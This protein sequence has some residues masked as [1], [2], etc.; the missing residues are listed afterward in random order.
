M[1]KGDVVSRSEP[2]SG[3]EFIDNAIIN[4]GNSMMVADS[5]R[6]NATSKTNYRSEGVNALNVIQGETKVSLSGA[7]QL[8]IGLGGIHALASDLTTV[9]ADVN[10]A[11]GISAAFNYVDRSV[12]ALISDSDIRSIDGDLELSAHNLRQVN[13]T[14]LIAPV[15]DPDSSANPDPRQQAGLFAV[16]VILGKTE[17]SIKQSVIETLS[18]S[19]QASNT[20]QVSST[21]EGGIE[22]SIDPSSPE[23]QPHVRVRATGVGV[24]VN[25]IGYDIK[26]ALLASIDSLLGNPGDLGAVVSADQF[27]TIADSELVIGGQLS[28]RA[29][30]SPALLA[31]ISNL[32][33]ADAT[34]Q[35]RGRAMSAAGLIAANRVNSHTE[36]L[37]IVNPVLD[38]STVPVILGASGVIEATDATS[39]L[40]DI[41]LAST[42]QLGGSTST[43]GDESPPPSYTT[44]AGQVNGVTSVAGLVAFNELTGGA[45]AAVSGVK[46]LVESGNFDVLASERSSVVSKVESEVLVNS[47]ITGG[48][49][50]YSP[51]TLGGSKSLGASG[52]VAAN[53]VVAKAE[54]DVTQS[55]IQLN[56]LSGG[57]LTIDALNESQILASAKNGVVADLVDAVTGSSSGISPA[58]TNAFGVT[59]AVNSVGYSVLDLLLNTLD[60]LLG[61]RVLEAAGLPGVGTEVGSGATALLKDSVVAVTGSVFVLAESTLEIEASVSNTT[62]AS[63]SGKR[64]SQALSLGA[65]I[66]MNRVSAE[67]ESQ[68]DHANSPAGVQIAAATGIEVMAANRAGISSTIHL[69]T[70]SVLA[71]NGSTNSGSYYAYGSSSSSPIDALGVAGAISFNEIKGGAIAE[72]IDLDIEAESGAIH[73]SALDERVISAK[74]VSELSASST[75]LR[76]KGFGGGKAIGVS[77][78]VAANAVLGATSAHVIRSSVRTRGVL[79]GGDLTVEA[80]SR[81]EVRAE[82]INS[83]DS[84]LVKPGRPGSGPQPPVA[85]AASDAVG[86]VLA[87]N[88]VGWESPNLLFNTIDAILG[89]PLLASAFGEE[90]GAG[91]MAEIRDSRVDVA[92]AVDVISMLDSVIHSSVNNTTSASATGQ[93]GT[94]A[95]SLG[96][97]LALNKISSESVARIEFSNAFIHPLD[98]S[99]ER[100]PNVIGNGVQVRSVDQAAIR[101]EI[102]LGTSSIL[103]LNQKTSTVTYGASTVAGSSLGIAGAISYNEVRSGSSA[104]I[105]NASVEAL[106]GDIVVEAI[107]A[108]VIEARTTSELAASSED[109]SKKRVGSN[110]S[111]GVSGLVSINLVLNASSARL[112]DA[113]VVTFDTAPNSG[114]VRI[115][116]RNE[117]LIEALTINA[118]DVSLARPGKPQ[119]SSSGVTSADAFGVT[120][121]FNS[122]GWDSQNILFNTVDALLGDTLVADAFGAEVGAGAEAIVLDSRILA[123]GAVSFVARAEAQIQSKITN[124]SSATSSGRNGIQALSLGA[125]L[126]MNKV[127]GRAVAEI[128]FSDGFIHPLSELEERL[129]DLLAG[130]G[131][132]VEAQNGLDIPGLSTLS[133]AVAVNDQSLVVV[134]SGY[135]N[136]GLPGAVYRFVGP[137]GNANLG[138]ENYLDQARWMPVSNIG[139]V[140]ELGVSSIVNVEDKVT[141][142]SYGGGGTQVPSES[143]GIAGAISYNDIR[144]GARAMVSHT[145]G[146]VSQHDLIIR[147]SEASIIQSKIESE[148]LARSSSEG[149][150][151]FGSAKTLGVSGIIA[152]NAVQSVSNAVAVESELVTLAEGDFGDISISALDRGSVFA[153]AY[154]AAFTQYE[155]EAFGSSGASS[156]A[157]TS[158]DVIGVTLA[159]NSVGWSPQN[160]LFNAI[161]TLIGAPIVSEAIDSLPSGGASALVDDTALTATGSIVV[162]A[163][164]HATILSDV[165]N[166][167]TSVSSTFKGAT[168][169]Q[170]FGV[171]VALNKVFGEATAKVRFSLENDQ[172]NLVS[173]LGLELE[174]SN[175]SAIESTIRLKSLVDDDNFGFSTQSGSKTTVVAAAVALNDLRGGAL[176]E[177]VGGNVEVDSGDIVVSGTNTSLVVATLSAETMASGVQF[178]NENSS[179]IVNALIATNTIRGGA[180]ASVRGGRLTTRSLSGDVSIRTEN[181]A[182]IDSDLLNT[183]Q[184]DHLFP[185]NDSSGIA[186]SMAF[187]TVGWKSQNLLFNTI[188]AFLGGG[189]FGVEEA[190]GAKSLVVDVLITSGG[191]LLVDSLTNGQVSSD[192]VVM[193]D[194]SSLATGAGGSGQSD[195]KSFSSGIVVSLNKLSQGAESIVRFSESFDHLV[196]A[197]LQ[198]LP[199]LTVVDS[200]HFRSRAIGSIS[201]DVLIDVDSLS[202]QVQSNGRSRSTA[203]GGAFALNDLRGGAHAELQSGY[204]SVANGDV[205]FEALDEARIAAYLS[206]SAEA[207]SV[208]L[209]GGSATAVN[210]LVATNTVLGG[211]RAQ[212]TGLN[213]LSRRG[214][215]TFKTIRRKD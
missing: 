19:V 130:R 71:L 167:T 138:Q 5:L 190:A 173:G 58:I 164:S 101:S 179:L 212:S 183:V 51:G 85:G 99:G 135:Q 197:N 174:A 36:A 23:S 195:S 14:T 4:V 22:S 69:G 7:N 196:D 88:T 169:G 147:S 114:D 91:V 76:K 2:V 172:P 149:R 11:E 70:D 128:G 47:Q 92:G 28:L 125:V 110:R 120:I 159:F 163:E 153:L 6:L 98:L 201:S 12:K 39:L 60:S 123:A 8:Q 93:A 124:Q 50:S 96:A 74:V 126:A 152:T 119:P 52:V 79:N 146:R 35:P 100:L 94:Q 54:A 38:A 211:A 89:D 33:T 198:V 84:I 129:P 24:A 208:S 64:G 150:K 215:F 194:T 139:S 61:D 205:Q 193:V 207:I 115:E 161:D 81:S 122:I 86:V 168:K 16:N 106:M 68:I 140:I 143:I 65:V 9:T 180:I 97:V 133:G 202:I 187:N 111:L 214:T 17:A 32:S 209:G 142:N 175:Q 141:T 31:T 109:I 189:V 13:A 199:D 192:S 73:V 25:L 30:A 67:A 145:I 108:A 171:V 176:A 116:S 210:A 178:G 118:V 185:V 56:D 3:I 105:R 42:A 104:T 112:E 83:A 77:G 40:S 72:V 166:T 82:A 182:T 127:S 158:N 204:L 206:S 134:E 55:E 107:E 113:I 49:T 53:V 45:R 59:M 103:S 154:N 1:T 18:L 37:L 186:V 63:T 156:G 131:L 95:L 90:L 184:D 44:P 57:A 41:V 66:S 10:G 62:D 132:S 121:A 29:T 203:I 148:L 170:S 137:S 144:G 165:K 21:L 136:G 200:T 87:F 157:I 26:D 15:G 34:T 162:S 151:S 188:E 75:D 80:E 102:D 155:S 177:L 27:A 78:I 160:I 213:H 117:A 191:K 46:V 43:T 48:N 181:A 20:S